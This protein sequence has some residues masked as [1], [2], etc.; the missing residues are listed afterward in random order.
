MF[1]LLGVGAG[2]CIY[3]YSGLSKQAITEI[4]RKE[5]NQGNKKEEVDLFIDGR[6]EDT[7]QILVE[8][9]EYS[10]EE[11]QKKFK[12]Y[13]NDMDTIILGKNESLDYV[14][15]R[16]NLIQKIPK[17]PIR[18]EWILDRYDVINYKGELMEDKLPEK[19]TLVQ[20]K[21]V[22][23]YERRPEEQAVYE[24][25]VML[26]PGYLKKGEKDIHDIK[27]RIVYEEENSRTEKTFKLPE[28]S[29]GKV[30]EYR[31]SKE[32][33]GL[34]FVVL[35]LSIG[36]LLFFKTK[37][38]QKNEQKKR[39]EQMMRDYPFLVNKMILLLQAGMSMG[40][41]W[42]K[43]VLEY[44]KQIKVTGNRFVYEEMKKTWNQSKSGM[45]FVKSIEEFGQRCK[46]SSYLKLSAILAQN[47]RKGNK[48]LVTMLKAEGRL[49]FEERKARAKQKGEEAGTKLLLPM[50]MM[51]IIALI[52]VIIPAFLSIQI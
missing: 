9:T 18:I 21:G 42:D 22:L 37:Q 16:L 43:M 5:V 30:F 52:I 35:G 45:S 26:Y 48:G 14:T 7:L 2:F 11:I 51:L 4:E 49:A 25:A 23:T 15:E 13:C 10:R 12:K 31:V 24:R 36:V 50:F 17:E 47:L 20:L 33:R 40:Q 6:K 32:N 46:K 8:E 34:S 44:E 29:D 19:G 28:K 27:E 1:L 38:D 3:E 39:E 41:V